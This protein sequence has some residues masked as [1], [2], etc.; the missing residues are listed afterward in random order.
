MKK[1]WETFET[2]RAVKAMQ[3]RQKFL[4]SLQIISELSDTITTNTSEI[5]TDTE[6]SNTVIEQQVVKQ[7][8]SRKKSPLS[9]KKKLVKDELPKQIECISPQVQIDE[10]LLD[11]SP[12]SLLKPKISL[13]PLDLKSFI[14]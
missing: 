11:E 10:P 13:P 14:K 8:P 2:G 12:Q 4:D 3:T 6:T 9:T 5:H 1:A 7:I